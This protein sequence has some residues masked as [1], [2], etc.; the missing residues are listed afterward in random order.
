MPKSLGWIPFLLI[1]AVAGLADSDVQGNYFTTSDGVRLH[2]LDEGEGPAIVF[3]PGWM[4]PASIWEPQV[5][6]FAANYRVVVLDP[7]SQGESEQV[8]EG[9][10]PER[11]SRDIKELIK[12][13]EVSSVVLVGFSM[14][15][16][17]VLSYVDQFGTGSLSGIVLVD[18]HIGSDFDARRAQQVF[19]M[20]RVFNA[21]RAQMLENFLPYAFKKPQPEEYMERIREATM[22]MPSNTAVALLAAYQ[23][24]D[25]R[26][27]LAK[28]DKPL[29]YTITPEMEQQGQMVERQLPS[30]RVERFPEAGHVIFA[31]ETERF[32]SILEEFLEA[33]FGR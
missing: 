9:H 10:Y 12:H 6:Y 5:R 26:P 18:N 13:L 29:L 11:R 28:L 8:T 17:E 7:R 30:A 23:G 1:V 16:P 22:S 15:G 2:Y 19:G 14:G 27:V 33:S 25:W 3:I 21:D 32:N 31:D 20:I 4:N 24:R